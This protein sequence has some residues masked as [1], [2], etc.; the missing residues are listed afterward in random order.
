M[1]TQHYYG[2]GMEEFMYLEKIQSPE[3][4][5]KLDVEQLKVLAGE[6]RQALIQKLSVHGGH[7]GPNLGMVEATIAMHYVFDSPKDKMVFDVSHQSYCHKMLTGRA[8]AFLDEDFTKPNTQKGGFWDLVDYTVQKAEE[9]GLYLGLLP[10]WSGQ[11]KAKR[12][13]EDNVED[14]IQFLTDRYGK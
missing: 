12:I 13:T 5:K 1:T 6:M 14:Y 3:D 4:V 2:C 9:Y 10:I 11:F 7:V 8:D